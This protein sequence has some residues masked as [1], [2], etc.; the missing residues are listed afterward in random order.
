MRVVWHAQALELM[1]KEWRLDK[2]ENEQRYNR[3]FAV[4]PAEDARF[5]ILPD[6]VITVTNMMGN[7]KEV[8]ATRAKKVQEAEKA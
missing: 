5:N 1:L 7:S 8:K 6:E 3:D 2:K 4:D